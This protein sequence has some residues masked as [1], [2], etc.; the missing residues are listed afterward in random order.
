MLVDCCFW[1]YARG[2]DV[3]CVCVADCFCFFGWVYLR[4]RFLW[5]VLFIITLVLVSFGEFML[6]VAWFVTLGLL[7]WDSLWV[8]VWLC[9]RW[10][11]CWFYY[12]L[13][14]VALV[15]LLDF[16]VGSLLFCWVICII[17]IVIF[18]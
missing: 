13:S 12:C 2:Y 15:W 17:F 18:D 3:G 4:V 9:S 8:G 11:Y 6:S 10:L 14:W 7:L 16:E 1:I 5:V